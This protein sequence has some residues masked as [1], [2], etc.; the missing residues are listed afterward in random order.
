MADLLNKYIKRE[1][2]KKKWRN[3]WKKNCP[4]WIIVRRAN[5]YING[6]LTYPMYHIR[7]DSCGSSENIPNEVLLELVKSYGN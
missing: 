4:H 3:W 1:S 5:Y 2:K 6:D 7:C